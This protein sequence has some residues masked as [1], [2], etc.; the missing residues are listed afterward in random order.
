MEP[1][2]PNTWL[3]DRERLVTEHEHRGAGHGDDGRPSARSR[4]GPAASFKQAVIPN[5]VGVR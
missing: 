4:S 1:M 5:P 3:V 2:G